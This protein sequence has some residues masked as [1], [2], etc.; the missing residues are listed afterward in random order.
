MEPPCF[1]KT[2][3]KGKGKRTYSC[4]GEEQTKLYK[5][6]KLVKGLTDLRMN[7]TA[8]EIKYNNL[9]AEF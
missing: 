3:L 8:S 2:N 5:A 1:K 6:D 9:T 4:E 7:A